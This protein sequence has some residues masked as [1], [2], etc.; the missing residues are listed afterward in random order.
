VAGLGASDEVG[1]RDA[2]EDG[3]GLV[4]DV[5]PDLLQH[6]VPIT[7]VIGPSTAATISARVIWSAGRAST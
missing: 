1:K 4:G 5:D 3:A 6:A 7:W 2:L